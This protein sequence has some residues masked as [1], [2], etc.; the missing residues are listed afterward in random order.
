MAPDVLAEVELTIRGALS[1]SE[2]LRSPYLSA[3]TVFSA[4]W[5]VTEFSGLRRSV[6]D[7]AE[8]AKV[9]EP[10]GSDD[11]GGSIDSD[12]AEG[13]E[14]P[15]DVDLQEGQDCAPEEPEDDFGEGDE[16]FGDAGSDPNGSDQTG[17]DVTIPHLAALVAAAGVHA[18]MG[19]GS[20]G[21]SPAEV[22]SDT[23]FARGDEFERG[24]E[25]PCR[26]GT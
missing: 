1:L 12:V 16:T 13:S 22:W 9:F 5:H 20:C 25:R 2:R 24:R 10:E 6:P 7:S 26:L 15:E 17:D 21:S 4:A 18:R 11:S 19:P 8:D 23:L 3:E 14:H